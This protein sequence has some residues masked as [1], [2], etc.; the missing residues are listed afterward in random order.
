MAALSASR[1]SCPAATASC[2]ALRRRRRPLVDLELQVLLWTYAIVFAVAAILF[3][4]LLGI[5][6]ALDGLDR[7]PGRRTTGPT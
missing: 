2:A 5:D 4:D 6:G 1:R 7:R 3:A